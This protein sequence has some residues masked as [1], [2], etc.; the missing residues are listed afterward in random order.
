MGKIFI[1]LIIVFST[2]CFGQNNDKFIIREFVNSDSLPKL[3]KSNFKVNRANIF[4]D[5]LYVVSK[6][7][8]GEWGGTIRF[9]NKSTGIEYSA[10]STCP[11]VVNKIYDKYYIT[12]TLAHMRGSS[13]ILEILNPDSLTVI[14]HP[15][16][17]NE[18]GKSIIRYV[19]DSETKSTRGTKQLVDSYGI[20]TL[21]SFPYNGQLYH[22]ITDS[23]KTLLASIENNKFATI[24]IV[25]DISIWTYNPEVF[26]T[27]DKHY[28][29]FFEN[30]ESNG[31]LDIFE[32]QVTVV[33]DK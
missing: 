31:Y 24:D 9:K 19:G 15:K 11:V 22:I 12:N 3:D 2:T 1:F 16:P 7:C 17:R 23:Q 21:A 32:N 4:E 10:A 30:Q 8:S 20:M 14:E 29:V 27:I 28:I 18:K 6:S 25:S 26:V 33:R 5:N 13:E